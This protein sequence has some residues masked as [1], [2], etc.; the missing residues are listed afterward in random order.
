MRRLSYEIFE[1]GVIAPCDSLLLVGI[2]VRES[3]Y[4]TGLA[5]EESMEVWS[6]LVSAA[7]LESVALSTS[8]LEKSSALVLHL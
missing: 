1:E 5:T 8:G 6:D 2:S 3:L 4:L 7:R